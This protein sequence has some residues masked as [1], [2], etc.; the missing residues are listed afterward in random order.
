VNAAEDRDGPGEERE[1][2][3]RGQGED[4]VVAHVAPLSLR[5]APW[6][7][8]ADIVNR[9]RVP[10]LRGAARCI[11]W[12]LSPDPTGDPVEGESGDDDARDEQAETDSESEA[13][14][15]DERPHWSSS[16]MGHPSVW[17]MTRVAV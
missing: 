5:G 13:D 17:S 15:C 12:R 11:R 1:D 14:P 6:R 4:D 8:V 2:S 9:C 7:S 3:A 16:G 10:F